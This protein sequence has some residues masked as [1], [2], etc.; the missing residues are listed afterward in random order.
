MRGYSVLAGL[1]ALGLTGCA[2][3]TP[4]VVSQR[5]EAMDEFELCLGKEAK[6]DRRTTALEPEIVAAIQ[7]QAKAKK[8]D[9]ASKRPEIIA[10]LVRSLRDEERRNEQFKFHFGFGIFRGY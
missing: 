3:L 7:A 9:C 1:C 6:M 2:A 8:L 4:E 5:V 10:F